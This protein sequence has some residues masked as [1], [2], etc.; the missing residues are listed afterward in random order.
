MRDLTEARKTQ[1]RLLRLAQ[2]D[3]LTGLANRVTFE[4]RAEQFLAHAQRYG[5]NGALIYLD[6]DGFKKVND[7]SG[8]LVGDLLLLA[9]SHRLVDLLRDTDV[10]ARVGGDEFCVL[11]DHLAEDSFVMVIARRIVTGLNEP[12][13]LDGEE[14]QISASV[15]IA[16]LRQSGE[17]QTDLTFR[18]EAAM[19]ASKRLGGN[20]ATLSTV[21]DS[22]DPKAIFV[23]QV[24]KALESPD[25]LTLF[26]E[27]IVDLKRGHTTGYQAH[28]RWNR[29]EQGLTA[30]GDL[31]QATETDASITAAGRWIVQ[32]AIRRAAMWPRGYPEL[33]IDINLSIIQFLDPALPD[34]VSRCAGANAFGPRRV[35]IGVS[36]TSV[37]RDTEAIRAAIAALR[38]VGVQTSLNGFGLTDSPRQ[39]LEAMPF[40]V[41]RIDRSLV[42]S[43]DSPS[44]EL[45]ALIEAI[46]RT[47]H[48]SGRLVIADGVE[49][50]LQQERA[51][52]LGCDRALGRY[53]GLPVADP[54][55]RVWSR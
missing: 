26:Y 46:V 8:Q 18:A 51:A 6:L 22:L 50:H 3:H 36:A 27:P 28:L 37:K 5:E 55:A 23:E 52:A 16:L 40:D 15:G 29:E 33:D 38:E 2:S 4:D 13:D 25:A 35:R 44:R 1:E 20:R 10:I 21:D 7:S 9:V 53:F 32:R 12:F 11:V 30:P 34:N 49:T 41:V 45:S 39:L 43:M 14:I 42:S 48:L 19:H 47:A 31:I 17:S 54:F 24:E